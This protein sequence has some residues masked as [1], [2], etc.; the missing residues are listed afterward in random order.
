MLS[1]LG[2]V[3]LIV[4]V[5]ILATLGAIYII[6]NILMSTANFRGEVGVKEKVEADGDY[7]IAAYDEFY[8]LCSAIQSKNA[9]IKNIE[10]EMK[11]AD[12]DR[13]AELQ[14]AITAQRNVKAELVNEYNAKAT[15]EGTRGQFR[16][17]ELPYQI[18]PDDEE[19]S[20]GS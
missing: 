5:A 17:S 3:P 4:S 16:D 9:A 8:S 11:Y 7:R 20:C 12:K 6:G 19:V 2:S 13:K 18:K 14:S 10:A 15:A 1:K